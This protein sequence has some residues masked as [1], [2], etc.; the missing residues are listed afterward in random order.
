MDLTETTIGTTVAGGATAIGSGV[1]SKKIGTA[2]P[3]GATAMTSG[4]TSSTIGTAV[5]G[6]CRDSRSL[7][8]RDGD[9]GWHSDGVAKNNEKD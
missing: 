4:V 8:E 7:R 3:V 6:G 9:G 1:G 2:L 5:A